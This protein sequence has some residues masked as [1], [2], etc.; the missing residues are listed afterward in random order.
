MDEMIKTNQLFVD[1]LNQIDEYYKIDSNLKFSEIFEQCPFVQWIHEKKDEEVMKS[2][3]YIFKN[4]ITDV[5]T[6]ANRLER[7][8]DDVPRTDV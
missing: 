2:I 6:N 4:M 3:G 5:A 8:G 7:S 1:Y